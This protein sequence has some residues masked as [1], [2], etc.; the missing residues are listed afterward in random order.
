MVL[1]ES[2]AQ[3]KKFS[4]DTYCS[5]KHYTNLEAN[6]INLMIPYIKPTLIFEIERR[7]QR[8]CCI[9]VNYSEYKLLLSQKNSKFLFTKCFLHM[10]YFFRVSPRRCHCLKFWLWMRFTHGGRSCGYQNFQGHCGGKANKTFFEV[11]IESLSVLICCKQTVII[12][13]FSR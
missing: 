6:Q 3:A 8:G 7:D 11:I 4:L 1:L 5:S 2:F 9:N 12:V 10:R 13:Y